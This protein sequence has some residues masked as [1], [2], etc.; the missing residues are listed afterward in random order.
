VAGKL[1]LGLEPCS[2]AQEFTLGCQRDFS[3][4]ARMKL[5]RLRIPCGSGYVSLPAMEGIE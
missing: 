4:R 3:E 2:E 5:G 1:G